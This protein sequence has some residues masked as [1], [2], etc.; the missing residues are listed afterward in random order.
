MLMILSDSIIP[1]SRM[2]P[3]RTEPMPEKPPPEIPSIGAGA[4]GRGI[5][6]N[7]WPGANRRLERLANPRPALDA[8]V[9]AFDRD[10]FV[11]AGHVEEHTAFERYR[12][13]VV[14]RAAAPQRQWHWMPDG[15]RHHGGDFLLA[16]RPNHDVR[17]AI[18]ELGGQH[19]AIPVEVV[20]LL[21]NFTRVNRRADSAD[22]AAELLDE[23]LTCHLVPWRVGCTSRRL[24]QSRRRH[25]HDVRGTNDKN[26]NKGRPVAA[27][28]GVRRWEPAVLRAL[29]RQW[30]HERGATGRRD[31]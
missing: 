11:E 4:M 13:P 27:R 17:H 21:A 18:L 10:H 15:C 25:H 26:E 30:Q 20:G 12:L 16:L 7:F 1:E 6:L 23:R 19:R 22:V 14:A 28:N 2:M 3:W 5:L 31:R 8:N 9:A 24:D 29:A